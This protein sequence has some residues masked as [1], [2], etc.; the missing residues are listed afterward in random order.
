MTMYELQDTTFTTDLVAACTRG[1]KVRVVLSASEKSNNAS[2]YAAINAGGSNCS[3]V[4][5]NSAFTNTHQK[6]ITVDNTQTTIMSLN[7]QTQYYSTTRDF[8][9]IEND[10]ADIAAIE[11]TF[12]QDYA[13]AGTNSRSEEHTSE[14]QSP[15]Q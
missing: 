7:L 5:S 3:A 6:T 1:V 10:A 11:A 13:A 8:A 12:A 2:A 4:Y 9:V 14:L 15:R